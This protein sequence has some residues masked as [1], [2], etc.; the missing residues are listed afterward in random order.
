[1]SKEED[2]K[3]LEKWEKEDNLR[4]DVNKVKVFN[5]EDY[6]GVKKLSDGL[7]K[8]VKTI[9]ILAIIIGIIASI[10]ILLY[11]Y[12]IFTGPN[13]FNMRVQKGGMMFEQFY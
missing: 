3:E 5:E 10:A 6:K 9:S 13:F 4:K 7:N 12:G 8:F 1:M 11:L 2:W